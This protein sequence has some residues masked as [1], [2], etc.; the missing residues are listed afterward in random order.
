MKQRLDATAAALGLDMGRR[1]KSF[2]K[3]FPYWTSPAETEYT[4]FVTIANVYEVF[5]PT[6]NGVLTTT[7]AL[8]RE[9]QRRWHTV[10]SA[11]PSYE[12]S[13]LGF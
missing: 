8:A 3:N 5:Y 10:I 11:K 4:D 2:I 7:I 12:E 13:V 1:H 6:T 9:L